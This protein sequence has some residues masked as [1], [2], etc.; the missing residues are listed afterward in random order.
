[1]TKSA[2]KVEHPLGTLELSDDSLVVL[3]GTRRNLRHVDKVLR[4][5][6]PSWVGGIIALGPN[7]TLQ[8]LSQ[9]Q[10]IEL[11]HVLMKKFYPSVLSALKAKA[12]E[13]LDKA[14]EKADGQDDSVP[15]SD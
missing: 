13:L 15:S 5:S 8:D 3:R 4:K 10:E 1:M 14:K 9:D 6:R 7:E 11:C 12:E 2:T